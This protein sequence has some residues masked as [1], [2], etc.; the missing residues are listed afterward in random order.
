MTMD[1]NDPLRIEKDLLRD[2]LRSEFK[3]PR[4]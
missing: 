1:R 4:K 2:W 3:A